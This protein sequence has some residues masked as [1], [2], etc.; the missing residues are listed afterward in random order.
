MTYLPMQAVQKMVNADFVDPDI[1]GVLF[2]Q[3]K[4]SLSLLRETLDSTRA[5]LKTRLRG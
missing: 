3:F 5:V 4:I 2:V 1:S